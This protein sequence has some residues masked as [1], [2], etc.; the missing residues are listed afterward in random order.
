VPGLEVTAL[1]YCGRTLWIGTGQGLWLATA[2]GLARAEPPGFSG[3]VRALACRGGSLY[4]AGPRVLLVHDGEAWRPPVPIGGSGTVY[5]L[6]AAEDGLWVGGDGGAA[7]WD[8]AAGEWLTY[9]VPDDIPAGPVVGVHTVG[10]W[11]WLAT[12]AGALRLEPRS[13]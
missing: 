2:S 5:S 11:L 12:P 1:A 7:R 4:L 13:R 3:R 10:D 9:L 6:V 8:A